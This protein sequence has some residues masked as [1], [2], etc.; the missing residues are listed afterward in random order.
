MPILVWVRAAFNWVICCPSL[1]IPSPGLVVTM[2]LT[3]TLSQVSSLLLATFQA[4]TIS[5]EYEVLGV[6]YKY[7]T[8]SQMCLWTSIKEAILM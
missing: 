4:A 8:E 2:S 6:L 3:L 5:C 1:D 7:W